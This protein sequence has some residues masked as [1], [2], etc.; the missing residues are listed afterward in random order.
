MVERNTQHSEGMYRGGPK[1]RKRRIQIFILGYITA[2]ILF[3]TV[4]S[5]GLGIG[6]FLFG[7][8]IALSIRDDITELRAQDVNVGLIKFF[9]YTFPVI[10]PITS[11]GYLLYR[12]MKFRSIS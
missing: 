10:I 3:Q 11:I 1:S 6:H 4:F 8:I 7:I 5:G 2:V 12:K 9:F